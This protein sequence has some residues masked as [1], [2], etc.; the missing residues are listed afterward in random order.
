MINKVISKNNYERAI[1]TDIL[2]FDLPIIFNNEDLYD[3]FF[4]S[5]NDEYCNI[6][7]ES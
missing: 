5:H 4:I 6:I 3:N 2:P 1:I 7:I